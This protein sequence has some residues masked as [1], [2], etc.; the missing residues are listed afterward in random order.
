MK[1][2]PAQVKN[3]MRRG[4]RLLVD[5]D[6]EPE[7]RQRVYDYFGHQCAYCGIAVE[8]GA[9]DLD[10]LVSAALG[11]TNH[12]SNRVLS[13]KR[14]NAKEKRELDWRSFLGKM[15][16]D[17]VILSRRKEKIESWIQCFKG[18]RLLDAEM[19]RMLEEEGAKA[20]AVYDA[21]CRKVRTSR[22]S[23]RATR[24]A[25]TPPA[26]LRCQGGTGATQ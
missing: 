20:T 5:P 21:A 2:T 17:E 19:L 3:L 6:P 24:T 18:V 11:G 26:G 14:C 1:L 15:S 13:C 8:P 10:H 9:G 12:L 23:G 7:E 16:S 22:P 4:L 25:V